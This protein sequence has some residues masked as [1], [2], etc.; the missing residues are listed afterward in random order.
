MLATLGTAIAFAEWSGLVASVLLTG[1]WAY[2]A[3]LEE[4]AMIGQFG[5]EYERYRREVKGLVPFLW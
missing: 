3:R 1:S 5:A 4:T 2:K